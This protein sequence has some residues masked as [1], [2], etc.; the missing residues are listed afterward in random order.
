MGV[1]MSA[2]SSAQTGISPYSPCAASFLHSSNVRF[3]FIHHISFLFE[4]IYARKKVPGRIFLFCQGREYNFPAV[5]PCFVNK[6][7][8]IRYYVHQ[9]YHYIPGSSRVPHVAVYS[10][11]Y[12]GMPS[13]PAPS[14]VHLTACV[15]TFLSLRSLCKCTRQSVKYPAADDWRQPSPLGNWKAAPFLSPHLRF[16]SAIHFFIILLPAAKCVKSFLYTSCHADAAGTNNQR[17]GIA[18]VR[19]PLAAIPPKPA[20]SSPPVFPAIY[21]APLSAGTAPWPC[22]AHQRGQSPHPGAYIC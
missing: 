19:H 7:A 15:P 9:V 3:V 17:S 10:R 14:V 2:S 18:R 16:I 5:P 13:F 22:Q 12:R 11:S 20:P 8:L 21:T 4:V 1:Q 6:D